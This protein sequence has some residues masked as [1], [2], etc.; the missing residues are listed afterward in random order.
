MRRS[1][2]LVLALACACG[3]PAS[4]DDAPGTYVLHLRDAADTL[5]LRP[6]GT[7]ARAYAADGAPPAV[8]T[9]TWTFTDVAD[10]P[11]VVFRG[12][13]FRAP[14]APAPNADPRGAWPSRIQRTA[15]GAVVLPVDSVEGARYH[16]ISI[17]ML[18]SGGRG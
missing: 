10:G 16:R 14:P 11:A 5:W 6:D 7:F 18:G 1:A 12:S 8:S 3:G 9:G 15:T 13:P 4:R 17:H 2:V